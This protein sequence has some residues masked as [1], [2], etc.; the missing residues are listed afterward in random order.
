MDTCEKVNV[1]YGG[2]TFERSV[3]LFICGINRSVPPRECIDRKP[4]IVTGCAQLKFYIMPT[5]K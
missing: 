2:K 1:A 4:S 5:L 3:R